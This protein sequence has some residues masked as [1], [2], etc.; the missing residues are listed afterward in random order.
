LIEVFQPELEKAASIDYF[1]IP[2]LLLKT[3]FYNRFLI[4]ILLAVNLK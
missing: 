1:I 4:G 3:C 2:S